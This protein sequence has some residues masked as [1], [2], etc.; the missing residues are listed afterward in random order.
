MT[1][2]NIEIEFR[3]LLRESRILFRRKSVNWERLKAISQKMSELMETIDS[4]KSATVSG[5]N[6]NKINGLMNN[7]NIHQISTLEN[8]SI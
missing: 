1:R 2:S 4:K 3:M 5:F 7:N 8:I 6:N